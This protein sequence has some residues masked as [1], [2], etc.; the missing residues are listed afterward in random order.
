MVSMRN[1][2]ALLGA[3]L[4]V[5]C[6]QLDPYRVEADHPP[7][8]DGRLPEQPPFSLDRSRECGSAGNDC[9]Q[10]VEYDEF[11]NAFSR[12]QLQAGVSAAEVVAENGGAV[13][14]YVHGW[15]HSASPGD[16]DIKHFH[17]IVSQASEH[18]GKG[19][20]GIYVG[21]RG[22]SIDA[23]NALFGWSSY[24]LTFWDRKSTAHTIGHGGGVSELIRKLSDIRAKNKES[25]L[26]VIGHSF[27]GAILYS[28][29]SQIFAEQIRL[30][31]VSDEKSFVKKDFRSIADLVVL[32]NP[33][34]E[35][36]RMA[37]LYALARSY[38]YPPDLPPRL[39]VV[40]TTADWATRYAFPGGRHLG[41]LF[42]RYPE[43]PSRALNTTAIGHY[44]PYVTHQLT[45]GKCDDQQES[46]NFLADEGGDSLLEA[47]NK[48][49]SSC[50]PGH[51]DAASVV[52]TRCDVRGDCRD[53]VDEHYLTRGPAVEGYIPKRFPIANVRT[54]ATVI[55]DH[56]DIWNPTMSNFLFGLLVAAMQD[57][58]AI[59][60]VPALPVE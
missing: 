39:V 33:A 9:V 26:M 38:E 27:G 47:L 46:S 54:D 44:V 29:V 18:S 35:A 41:T 8:P 51:N 57:P 55:G 2:M 48:P 5:G 49:A 4:L 60:M 25:S 52:L 59:P 6:T 17:S 43:G 3:A 20:V 14:V 31:S 37:P 11:G 45:A 12:E 22:D 15:H 28:A 1:V 36:M 53:V 58:G 24:V 16:G 34:F 56:N 32:V 50:F 42:Q 10:F 40:T 19:A 13:I 30:D 7:G 21:W 23:E